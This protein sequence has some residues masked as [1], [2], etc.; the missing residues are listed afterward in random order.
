MFKTFTL[1]GSEWVMW[2]LMILSV[3]SFAI[4]FE[5]LRNLRN[6]ERLG[7]RLWKERIDPLINSGA[8]AEF[9]GDLA[10]TY[11]C[12]EGALVDVISKV[13]GSAGKDKLELL[14]SSFL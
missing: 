3:L 7:A 1:L 8:K 9:K 12:L 6:Q 5:R 13:D 4:V 14:T 10:A 2:L 11:P